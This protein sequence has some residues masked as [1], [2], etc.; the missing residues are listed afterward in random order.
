MKEAKVCQGMQKYVKAE[1][2]TRD[3][4]LGAQELYQGFKGSFYSQKYAKAV[5]GTRGTFW[6]PGAPYEAQ[7]HLSGPRGTFRGPGA[8]SGAIRWPL[9]WFWILNK[10]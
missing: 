4:L 6:G 10:V 8:P 1:A 5:A 9:R 3:S 2:G 7:G